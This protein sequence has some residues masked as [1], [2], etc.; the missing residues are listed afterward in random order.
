MGIFTSPNDIQSKLDKLIQVI[1]TGASS[2]HATKSDDARCS[3]KKINQSEGIASKEAGS[4]LYLCL[5]G[6]LHIGKL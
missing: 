4:A 3:T 5:L 2:C 6:I 1:T